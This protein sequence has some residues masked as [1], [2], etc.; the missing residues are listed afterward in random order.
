MSVKTLTI[1]GQPITSPRDQTVLDAARAHGI[2]VWRSCQCA[3]ASIWARGCA[4]TS[5]PCTTWWPA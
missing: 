5:R 4:A 3:P 2:M 1:D